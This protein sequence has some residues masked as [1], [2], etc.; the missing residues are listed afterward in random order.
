MFIESI[1]DQDTINTIEKDIKAMSKAIASLKKSRTIAKKVK[2][3]VSSG[4]I[5]DERGHEL[6]SSLHSAISTDLLI[7]QERGLALGSHDETDWV[8]SADRLAQH[9]INKA[10][11]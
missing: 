5:T 11:K 4:R 9:Y 8:I 1:N 7:I 10:T 6:L 3:A 2:I